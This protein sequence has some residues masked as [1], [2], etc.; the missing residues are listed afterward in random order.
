ML[1]KVEKIQDIT[2]ETTLEA[3]PKSMIAVATSIVV[4][5]IL[6]EIKK[7]ENQLVLQCVLSASK[8]QIS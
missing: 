3:F 6:K 7:S 1:E 4:R 2:F 5:H 8:I